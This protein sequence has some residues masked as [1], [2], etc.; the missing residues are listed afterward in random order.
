MAKNHT[1]LAAALAA[2]DETL[3]LASG[4]GVSDSRYIVMG[5]EVMQII[6]GTTAATTTP[7]VKRALQGTAPDTGVVGTA[8]TIMDASDMVDTTPQ[9]AITFPA[10]LT[11]TFDTYVAAGAISFGAARWTFAQILGTSAIAMT[12]ANPTIDQNGYLIS[13]ITSAK[14]ASTLTVASGVGGVGNAGASYDVLTFQNAGNLGITF[15]ASN[16]FWVTLTP[17]ITG[18]TTALSMAIA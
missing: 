13:V 12:L 17:P 6:K 1:T 15:V 8:V 10:L 4:T 11:T 3:T 14:S 9:Q 5:G 16:G 18:T 2:T 7:R